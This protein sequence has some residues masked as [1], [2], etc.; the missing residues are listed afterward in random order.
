MKLEH[1]DRIL[2]KLYQN[3]RFQK[4]RQIFIHWQLLYLPFLIIIQITKVSCHMQTSTH[5]PYVL[6]EVLSS[7]LLHMQI[8]CSH[9]KTLDNELPAVTNSIFLYFLPKY[10]KLQLQIFMCDLYFVMYR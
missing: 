1:S 8:Y 9:S 7:H 10:L 2:W 4:T 5:F 3:F 6:C